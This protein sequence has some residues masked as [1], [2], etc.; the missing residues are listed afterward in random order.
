MNLM[1]PR[2]AVRI[3]SIAG[4]ILLLSGT[5]Y[6]VLRPAELHLIGVVDA[7]QILLSAQVP[8]R[9]ER[10]LV[11]EGQDVKAGDLLAIL[12]GSEL[13]AATASSEAQAASVASQ[14]DA[15]KASAEST[16]GEVSH[17]LASARASYEMTLAA[18]AEAEANRKRQ[19]GITQRT[20]QLAQKGALSAQDRD[21]AVSNLEALAAHAQSAAKAVEQAQAALRVAQARGNQGKAARENVQALLGQLS[22]ARA[23]VSG[24]EA[25]LGFT[26]IFAPT[27]GRISTLVARRGEFVGAGSPVL[28]L[29][30]F[31]QSWVYVALPETQADWVNVSDRLQ[32][33]MPSGVQVEGRVIA[34]AAEADFATQRDVGCE[35]RDIRAIRV[36]VLI[37]NPGGRY[38]PGMT[39]E[40][41]VR[42]RQQ[43]SK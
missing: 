6:A 31:Q 11:A 29:V 14:L 39:A 13:S 7:D 27:S 37:E 5:L 30:D 23:Q 18:L 20:L 36:K 38:V 33:T 8:G 34:K 19:E 15:A 4:A 40:I 26:K 10:L 35:K 22:A 43:V 1:S 21:T 24:A 16:L 41:V 42:K 9:I 28:T 2:N 32:V 17:G 3:S 12:E 25:R